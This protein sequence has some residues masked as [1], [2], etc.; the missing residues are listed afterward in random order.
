MIREAVRKRENKLVIMVAFLS[1][2]C[3]VGLN[4]AFRH[5]KNI[6]LEKFWWLSDLISCKVIR[7]RGKLTILSLFIVNTVFYIVSSKAIYLQVIQIIS[8]FQN[9]L[10]NPNKSPLYATAQSLFIVLKD[11]KSAEVM[12]PY[13]KD[14]KLKMLL[15][16][17]NRFFMST[18]A[19]CRYKMYR[20]RKAKGTAIWVTSSTQYRF[21]FETDRFRS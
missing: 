10:G 3:L 16:R 1:E 18:C 17:E 4:M 15:Q 13:S 8:I 6:Y 2:L 19:T 20:L 7:S 5:L 14:M 11:H 12:L 9:F 21:A